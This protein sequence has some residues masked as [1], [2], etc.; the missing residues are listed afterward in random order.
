ML[1]PLRRYITNCFSI[2]K[3]V[4]TLSRSVMITL[5][6]F[7]YPRHIHSLSCTTLSPLV[8]TQQIVTMISLLCPLSL[9]TLQIPSKFHGSLL[10]SILSAVHWSTSLFSQSTR[11]F[12]TVLRHWSTSLSFE[13]IK[14]F[15]TIHV[16]H[17]TFGTLMMRTFGVEIRKVCCVLYRTGR[18]RYPNLTQE[19]QAYHCTVKLWSDT[20][21]TMDPKNN[22][23]VVLVFVGPPIQLLS[24]ALSRRTAPFVSSLLS[25]SPFP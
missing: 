14:I 7:T 15:S 1:S 23:L 20:M 2:F 3:P 21:Y 13:S 16:Y 17:V 22:F 12:F 25:R 6:I 4:H 11:V 18:H 10:L 5:H 8:P 24:E 9:I 19:V